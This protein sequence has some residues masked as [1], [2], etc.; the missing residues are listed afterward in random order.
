MDTKKIL[1]NLSEMM[2]S[3]AEDPSNALFTHFLVSV[4]GIFIKGDSLPA[5]IGI[6][7]KKEEIESVK[8]F[9]SL[10]VMAGY[11]SDDGTFLI[12][13]KEFLPMEDPG[14][15]L[16]SRKEFT[17]QLVNMQLRLNFGSDVPSVVKS[18][19]ISQYTDWSD[20]EALESIRDKYFE[21]WSDVFFGKG[22]NEFVRIHANAS[23]SGNTY[24]YIFSPLPSLRLIPTPTW[25][26][27][28]NHA[29]GLP[30]VFGFNAEPTK[31]FKKIGNSEINDWELELSKQIIRYG[32]NFAKSG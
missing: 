9:R 4:D 3:A 10:D 20:P 11:N 32:S 6:K 26:K 8:Y 13:V 2:K 24:M 22:T 29:D 28:A 16:P 15:F 25:V 17:E 21:L 18:L 12:A 14:T 7:Y 5:E 30:F 1:A 27:G 19:V 23:D 31:D